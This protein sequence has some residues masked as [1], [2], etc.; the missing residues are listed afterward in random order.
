MATELYKTSEYDRL[1]LSLISPL[2][3][4]QDF[5]INVCTLLSNDG[6]HTLKVEKH[7]RIIDY[8]L[9]HAG[10]FKHGNFTPN[11]QLEQQE[12]LTFFPL[13]SDSLRKLFIHS[14]SSVRKHPIHT[15]WRD[16]LDNPEYICL[17]DEKKFVEVV[18]KKK[19][20]PENVKT[21]ETVNGTVPK[22]LDVTATTSTTTTTITESVT[23][24]EPV[25]ARPEAERDECVLLDN[26]PSGVDVPVEDLECQIDPVDKE[27]FSLGRNLGTRDYGGQRILQV[28]TIM[29]NLSFIDENLPTLI[30]NKTFIR[31]AVLCACS[32]WGALQNLGLDMVGN[33]ALDLIVQDSPTDFIGKSLLSF[34][35]EAL[36]SEDRTLWITALEVL[37]KLSQNERNEDVLARIIEPYVYERACSFLTIQDVM[38]LIYTLECLYSLSS[39]GEKPCNCIVGFHGVVDILVALVTVEGKSYGP[40]ACIGMK[41]VETVPGG[42]VQSA[43]SATASATST[44]TVAS[45][46]NTPAST[47]V[48]TLQSSSSVKAITSTPQR[49]VQIAPQ[50][51]IAVTPTTTVTGQLV[52]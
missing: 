20:P 47:T 45:A 25:S 13:L 39:L 19:K 27:L 23:I 21:E 8:L 9:A 52:A 37:N 30:G 16:V 41:L 22:C 43:S 32:K 36:R 31:F 26:E 14:Y 34:I 1:A 48:T 51:L 6:K 35:G 2:P 40:K 49:P 7:P 18:K 12:E 11:E 46:T 24:V 3:N 10:V 17:T 29:R 50:R 38:L 4:E 33:V 42:S 28:A 5:A 44:T 15:F